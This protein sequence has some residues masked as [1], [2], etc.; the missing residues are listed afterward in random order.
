MCILSVMETMQGVKASLFQADS[1]LTLKWTDR[2][3]GSVLTT[4]SETAGPK[5]SDFRTSDWVT[6]P[7]F[8]VLFIVKQFFISGV[9]E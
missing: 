4:T 1:Q 5:C 3:L 9:L 8:Y 2:R 7:A 6:H